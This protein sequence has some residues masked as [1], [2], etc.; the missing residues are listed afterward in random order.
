MFK[1]HLNS[2]IVK[3]IK[4]FSEERIKIIVKQLKN[5]VENITSNS[6]INI[7]KKKK[8]FKNYLEFNIR[9]SNKKLY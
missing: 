6:K 9:G 3:I 7:I 4:N 2:W 5:N 8:W 1:K